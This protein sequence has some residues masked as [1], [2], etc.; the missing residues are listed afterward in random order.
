MANRIVQA[1]YD[2]KD[3]ITGK[4]RTISESIRTNR[5]ESDKAAAAIERNNK[6]TSDSY[7]ATANAIGKVRGLLAGIGIAVGVN[8]AKDALVAILETGERF[9]DL[10]KKFATAFGGLDE[11]AAALEKIKDIAAGVP[12]G[13]EEVADAAVEMKRRGLDPLDGS[14]QAL[15]DNANAN[16]QSMEQLSATIEALGKAS[17]KGEVGMRALV[18]LTENGIPVFQLLG[19][20]TGQTEDQI[21]KLAESGE[22]GADSIKL[23]VTELG[24]LRAG[25]A[26]SEMGDLDSILQKLKDTA[27]QFFNSIAKAGVL[28]EFKL[29]L[30]EVKDTL[31]EME[32]DGT[33][34]KWAQETSD[35]ITKVGEVVSGLAGVF[36]FLSGAS[37]V[38]TGAVQTSFS[39]TIKAMAS[40][41]AV[42]TRAFADLTD[43][44]AETAKTFEHLDEVAS[45]KLSSSLQKTADGARSVGERFGLASD[46]GDKLASTFD[47]VESGSDSTASVFANVESG[48]KSVDRS[49]G[50]LSRT[51]GILENDSKGAFTSLGVD[52]EEIKS[53]FS[54]AG[55][56][57]LGS[58]KEA[59]LGVETLGLTA[60][61]KAEAISQAFDEAFGKAKTKSDLEAL[62]TEIGKSFDAGQIGAEQF[63]AKIAEVNEKLLAI[64]KPD[65]AAGGD[66]GKAALEKTTVAAQNLGDAVSVAG[67]KAGEAA[68]QVEQGASN[69]AQAIQDIYAG[70]ANELGRTSEAAV[71]RFT[72]LTRS[73]FE[74]GA[75]IADFSGLARFGKAAQDAFRIVQGEIV[76][77]KEGVAALAGQYNA[78]SDEAIRSMIATRGGVEQVS[79]SL[80]LLAEDARNGTT[81]FNLLGQQDLSQ[82]ESAAQAAADKVRQIGE[83]AKQAKE[84]LAGIASSLQDEIDAINGQQADIEN[85]R[86]QE[87]LEQI[88]RLAEEAGNLNSQEVNDAIERAKVLHELKLRQIAKEKEARDAAERNKPKDSGSGS[89][90]GGSSDPSGTP[91]KPPGGGGSSGGGSSGNGS[92]TSGR[93][94][95][96]NITGAAITQEL[97]REIKRIIEEIDRRS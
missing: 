29:K 27:T 2:L 54:S 97:A 7:T 94:Y 16:D 90:G 31:I 63:Q 17:I 75:G 92:A 66:A 22:L 55:K 45:T 51:L 64:G 89:S 42:A 83:E 86:Y 3:Q 14:L 49:V 87:Q 62:R 47:D 53:G 96:I 50:D 58:F 32:R 77:Q 67:D 35:N 23:I 88:R 30:V 70:F 80:D 60:A 33:L 43:K 40:G 46:A 44:G 41:S 93:T 11:G 28:D 12:Q 8:E 6:R 10:G 65:G 5:T 91:P 73:I 61:Q 85:R 39:A 18:S 76:L 37:D 78:L 26:A 95:T 4:L 59:T 57:A 9:D 25:A 15:L 36:R 21:R 56:V 52:I 84:Q 74:L 48:V 38:A 81:A 13:F 79:A 34:K 20:A 1:V 24:K 82:L 19:Q 69:A 71:A 68:D 72:T